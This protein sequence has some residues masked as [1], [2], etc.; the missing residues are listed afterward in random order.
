MTGTNSVRCP[1]CDAES[2]VLAGAANKRWM[3]DVCGGLIDLRDASEAAEMPPADDTPAR[4]KVHASR[5]MDGLT[6]EQQAAIRAELAADPDLVRKELAR[7]RRETAE[8]VLGAGARSPLLRLIG[9][10]VVLA[11]AFT[12]ALPFARRVIEH[13]LEEFATAGGG[14]V[15][16]LMAV[17]A[18]TAIMLGLGLL[19]AGGGL[20]FGRRW[21][22][23]ASAILVV[24]ACIV[25]NFNL[26]VVAF[27]LTVIL[28]LFVARRALS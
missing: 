14:I 3:C 1:H 15:A 5:W 22:A 23:H 13:T 26:T 8:K 4:A 16:D 20:A 21:G 7:V 2:V 24:L 27:A 25:F 28:A 19:G 12:V 9:S 11:G 17:S 10:V 18:P 6:P